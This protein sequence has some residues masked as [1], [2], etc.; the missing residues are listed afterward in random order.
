[1]RGGYQRRPGRRRGVR[2]TR[3]RFRRI[4]QQACDELPP[5]F[6]HLLHNVAVTVDDYPSAEVLREGGALGLYQ[7]TP[8]GERGTGYSMVLPD[9]ITIFRRP[10]LHA[11]HSQ[12]ELRDEVHLTVLHEIAHFFGMDDPDI[13]F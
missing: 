12:E 10:L 7:G 4:V 8:I 13:P 3:W 2:C 6:Q 11:C 9:K 1:M 5:R